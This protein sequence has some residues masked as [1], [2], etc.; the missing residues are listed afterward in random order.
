MRIARLDHRDHDDPGCHDVWLAAHAADDPFGPPLS[1]PAAWLTRA[2]DR[3]VGDLV[4][5]TRR[6]GSAAGTTSSSP[7]GRTG[8]GLCTSRCAP[9]P[10]AAEWAARCC[11]TRWSGQGQRADR[12]ARRRPPGSAGRGLRRRAGARG[13]PGRRAAR[14][15]PAQDPGRPGRLAARDGGG[16]GGRVLAGVVDGPTPEEHLARFAAVFNAMNDAPHSPAGRTTSGTRSGSAS[17]DDA[18][19]RE[20]WL[21]GY[22]SRRCGRDRRDGGGHQVF[23]DPEYPE[24]GHQG[25]TAVTRPHRGHRLGLLIK[26]AMLEWLATGSRSWSGSRPRTPR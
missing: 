22:R 11:G 6:P 3:T 26:A 17:D 1:L 20:G 23:V 9:R 24:W 14:A 10:G 12:A 7:T 8:T 21:R 18:R 13:E 5:W 19:D 4:A 16:G 15:G 25:L 2:S